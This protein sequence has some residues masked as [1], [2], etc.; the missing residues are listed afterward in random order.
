MHEIVVTGAGGFLGSHLVE[1]FV[2]DRRD[3]CGIDN[4]STG[5]RMNLNTFIT[6]ANFELVIAD[7]TKIRRVPV[8]KH[9]LHFASAASPPAYLQDPVGTLLV[10]SIGTQKILE[11]ARKADAVVLLASTSEVYGDPEVHPQ[12][13]SY[14]GHVNP[15][16]PRSCYD[17]GKR[18]MEALAV[19]YRKTYGLDIRVARIFN[20]YGPRMRPD[21]GRVVSNFITQGLRGTPLTIYGDGSQ[22]RSFCYVSDMIT[23]LRLLLEARPPVPSPIN[24][25]NP[26]EITILQTANLV[27]QELRIE[28]HFQ[29]IG[30][31]EDDPHV[32]RPDITQAITVLRW[33]PKVSFREGLSQSINYFRSLAP[34]DPGNPV[35]G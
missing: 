13:E 12:S 29:F 11:A 1:A 21:D 16:G 23:G 28:P 34:K 8:G 6:A 33:T 2:A 5:S 15:I 35:I 26:E 18:Y 32:R 22:T 20:T 27:C 30:L 25:G 4:F 3:V 17:E 9:Y 24:L 14:W 10:N 19:A 31:P 7:L